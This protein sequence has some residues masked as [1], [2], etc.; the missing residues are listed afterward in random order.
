MPKR[1]L[2]CAISF[3]LL[4]KFERIRV[5]CAL[6]STSE[7]VRTKIVLSS[8][9]FSM[10][11]HQ[12][13]DAS[14]DGPPGIVWR[15]AGRAAMVQTAMAVGHRGA[16][17]VPND[18]SGGTARGNGRDGSRGDLSNMMLD[19]EE[20]HRAVERNGAPLAPSLGACVSR[21]TGAF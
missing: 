19:G 17:S 6:A 21:Q 20:P 14:L 16:A 15:E 7:T 18:A 10:S 1:V 11:G 13:D 4:L 12:N 9:A 8:S 2:R 3:S 5:L